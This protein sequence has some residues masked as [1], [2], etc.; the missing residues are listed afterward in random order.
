MTHAIRDPGTLVGFHRKERI[1]T[2][3]IKKKN[4]INKRIWKG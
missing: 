1:L 2:V 3:G 4:G